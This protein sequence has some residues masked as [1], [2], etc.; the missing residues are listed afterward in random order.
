MRYADDSNVY[1]NSKQTGERVIKS[2]RYFITNRFK[3]KVNETK[4]KVGIPQ[5]RKFLGFTFTDGKLPDRR[6][7][8]RDSIKRFRSQVRCLTRR[9]WSISLDD[10]M[11]RLLWL[12]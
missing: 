11:E 1:V 5:N 6:K 7:I 10:R 8:S 4:S 3:Q 9:N 12:L 2:V